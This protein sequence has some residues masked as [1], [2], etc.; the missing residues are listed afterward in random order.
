MMYLD[1]GFLPSKDGFGFANTWRDVVLGVIASRGRCG[2]MVFAALDA[3]V[4]GAPLPPGSHDR[5]LPEHDSPLARWIWRRQLDSI[6]VLPGAN[7]ARFARFTYLP[8]G[9]PLG[10]GAATRQSL[11]TL[12]DLLRSGRPAPLGLVS[13]LGLP[14]IARNHQVLAYAADFREDDVVVR[15][16]DPNRPLRDDVVLEVPLD[17]SAAVEERG[18]GKP[19][20]WRGF[21]V[22]DYSPRPVPA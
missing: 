15:I 2:G 20:T 10:V 8:S 3:F 6:V 9:G 13:G 7:I 12:F 19:R 21:F 22:E 18:G 1:T 17:P 5:T 14:H 11:L 16:Y 4:A